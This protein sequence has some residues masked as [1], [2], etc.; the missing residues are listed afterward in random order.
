MKWRNVPIPEAHLVAL[1]LGVL[2]HL[3][4]TV[5]LFRTRWLGHSL[6]WPLILLGIW[7]ALWSVRKTA[8]MDISLPDK[9][10]VKGPYASSRNP[11][12]VGW[13]SLHLGI[14][15]VGN[16]MW[17]LVL[18]PP[19][20]AYIY[21]FEIRKEEKYLEKKFGDEYANYRKRVRRYL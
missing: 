13:M 3:L 20:I 16:S 2:F 9:L 17:I 1:S 6:G 4:L 19:V 5:E 7:F 18:F 12:Y 8:Q 21:F 14:A 11:M 10:L 15:L